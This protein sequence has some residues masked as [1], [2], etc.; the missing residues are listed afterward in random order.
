MLCIM[1]PFS[2]ARFYI[3]RLRWRLITNQ[4]VHDV[5][6]TI[7]EKNLW[8]SNESVS[9]DGSEVAYTESL[10]AWLIDNIPKYRIETIVDAPCGDFNWMRHVI[11]HVDVSYLG[12]DIVDKLIESN[13]QAYGC[14]GINFKKLNIISEPIPRCELLFVRDCLFH[15]S[16]QDINRF[17]ANIEEAD[18]K[19]LLTTSHI[20]DENFVNTDIRTGDFRIIDL[21]KPPF[22]FNKDHI[23]DFVQDYPNDHSKPKQMILIRK[24]FVP[25]RLRVDEN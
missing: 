5:F 24:E 12:I 7:Y 8:L 14:E 13:T 11:S 3:K 1:Y 17:L 23:L 15:F 2:R 25:T 18:Y 16:N 20:V 21:F 9:G 6:T 10:R 19:Y 4:E 22:S